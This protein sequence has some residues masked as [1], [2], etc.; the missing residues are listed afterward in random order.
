MVRG[1]ISIKFGMLLLVNLILVVGLISAQSNLY[2]V[3]KGVWDNDGVE[4]KNVGVGVSR[5]ELENVIDPELDSYELMVVGL[6]GDIVNSLFTIDNRAIREG[7]DEFGVGIEHEVVFLDEVDFKVYLPY[8]NEGVKIVILDESG[9]ELSE[10]EIY[11]F[12]KGGRTELS[13]REYDG[14]E[15]VGEIEENRGFVWLF[16]LVFILI[17]V[18]VIYYIVRKRSE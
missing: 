4:I 10:F 9:N 13:D 16:I 5:V 3:V 18:F 2:Y 15:E 6:D 14:N 17:L 12:S 11:E 7:F 8:S 1:K